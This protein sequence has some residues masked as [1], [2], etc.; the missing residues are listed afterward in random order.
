V[1][2]ELARRGILYAPDYLVNA[3]ALIRG[4]EFYLQKRKDSTDSVERIYE[5]TRRI[6]QLARD[7]QLAPARIADEL[8]E[9]RVRRARAARAALS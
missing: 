1:A 5:R 2:D 4:S 8:A 7:R 6:L 3:G 9:A